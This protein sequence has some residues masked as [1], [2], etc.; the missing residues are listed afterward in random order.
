MLQVSKD[1]KR[2]YQSLGVSINPKFWDFKKNRLRP[3]CPHKEIVQK[4]INDKLAEF[5]NRILE[6]KAEKKEFTATTGKAACV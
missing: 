4:I 5:Q 1:G 3:N 2:H 6:L